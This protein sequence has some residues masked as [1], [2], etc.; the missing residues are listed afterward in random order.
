MSRSRFVRRTLPVLLVAVILTACGSSTTT[1][2]VDAKMVQQRLDQFVAAVTQPLAGSEINVKADGGAK[3]ETASDGSVTGTLPRLLVTNKDGGTATL[4]PVSLHFANGGDGLVN[5][6]LKMPASFSIKDK[7]GKVQGQVQIGS[8]TLKAVWVEKLQTLNDVEMRLSNL[9]ISSAIGTGTGK[10]AEIALTGKIDPKGAGLYD[11]KYNMSM[12]GFTVDDP[13]DKT[14]TKMD[15]L[16]VVS[17]FSG[18]KLED[19]AKAAKAAGYTLANPDLFKAWTGGKMDAKMIAFLKTMPDYMGSI[20]YVYSI[21]GISASHDGK[22]TFGLKTSSMGFGASADGQGTTKVIMKLNL[23]GF[24]GGADTQMLPPE[25]DV[26]TAAMEIVATGVPGKKLWDIY[27]DALPKLQAEAAKVAGESAAAGGNATAAGTTALEEVGTEMSG[28][29]MQVL[30]AAK[31]SIAFNQL[32]LITPT[33]RMAGKGQA[34]YLPAES[35]FPDGKISLRFTGVDALAKAMQKRGDKDEMAQ[36]IMG[37][38]AAVR[39]MGKPDPTSSAAD[40]AYII[41]IVITKGGSITANG[42][43]LMGG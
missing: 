43:K 41:D 22:P 11:G 33:A 32:S 34:T 24:A 31:L 4:D 40:R 36:Q 5:L 2:A 6:E 23:G 3:V 28:Q 37:M 38:V 35:M 20:D 10:I 39:A 12:T 30:S 19:W 17:N 25:A 29:L 16:S 9:A 26:Q 27:M 18:A 21:D 7:A 8:Q 15:R 13:A 14:S 42:Q 1:P